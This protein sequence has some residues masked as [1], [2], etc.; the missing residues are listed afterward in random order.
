M[1]VTQTERLSLRWLTTDDA[2]F[3]LELVND[4]SW[5]RY[6]GDKGIHTLD[7][8]RQYIEN[9]PIGMYQRHGFGL[10]MVELKWKPEPVGICGLIKRD[11]LEDVDIGFAFLPAF[12]GSGYALEAAAGAVSHARR[13]L[14]LSRIVAILSRDNERSRRLLLKLGFRPE[15]TIRLQADADEVELY[16]AGA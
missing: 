11:G 13:V 6:I 4:P 16:A 3:I 1:L 8:A 9:G 5:I 12:R 14:G 7:D 15:G 2:A 10:N